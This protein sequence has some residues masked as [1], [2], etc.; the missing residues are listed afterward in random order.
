MRVLMISMVVRMRMGLCMRI[1]MDGLSLV[2]PMIMIGFVGWSHVHIRFNT[3][4][5]AQA[6]P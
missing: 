1:V 5:A 2:R 6:A 4:A 3:R